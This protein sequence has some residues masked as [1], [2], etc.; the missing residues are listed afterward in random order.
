MGHGHHGKLHRLRVEDLFDGGPAQFHPH[1]QDHQ[2]H[3]QPGQ[4]FHAAVAEGV[5]GVGLLPG[6]LEA[7][8]VTTEEPAS[9]Q[10]IE[11]IRRDGDGSR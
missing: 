11:G 8:R 6:Q 10:V 1:Q 2:A 4:V 5:A 7:T 3:Q 9:D